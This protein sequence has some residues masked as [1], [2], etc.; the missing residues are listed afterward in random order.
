M[1]KFLKFIWVLLLPVVEVILGFLMLIW[2]FTI[3]GLCIL[4]APEAFPTPSWIRWI[5][6]IFDFILIVGLLYER[7]KEAYQ[8]VYNN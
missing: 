7:V 4:L 2:V 6:G 3:F 8:E 5:I 1:K